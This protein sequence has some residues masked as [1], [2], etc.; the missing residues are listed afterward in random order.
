MSEK[1]TMRFSIPDPKTKEI[2][3]EN[4]LPSY[5]PGTLEQLKELSSKRKIVED[6]V[7]KTRT[8]SE[9]IAREMNRGL[10]SAC[11]QD[12]Y[13]LGQYIPLLVNLIHYIHKLGI[14]SRKARWVSA[15]KIRWSS[16][17]I[18][19]SL[20]HRKSPKFFQI[21][22]IMFE[23]GMILFLYAVKLRE[24]AME[25]ISIDMVQSATLYREAAGVFHHLSHEVLPGLQPSLPMEKPAEVI[26]SVCS[27]LSL[28][29]LAEG[30]AV[31]VKRAEEKGTSGS[32]LAKLHYGVTQLAGEANALLLLSGECKDL[33]SRFLEYVSFLG[34]LHE[35]KSQKHLAEC[36]ASEE[37]L[38]AAIGVLHRGLAAAAGRRSTAGEDTWR[39]IFRKETEEVS[40]RIDKYG[41]ENDFILRQK[42]PLETELPVPHGNKIVNLIPYSPTGW[43]REL[44][45]N[46]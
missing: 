32:L 20:L 28:L 22:D 34:A 30:Q 16:A 36:L 6:S 29:C 26:P 12:L 2:V 1:M 13:K 24:K 19:P 8:V 3:F 38:G 45:F 10:T 39:S 18:S 46:F 42:I 33:S 11:E 15:L 4:V 37:Q 41:R 7:N 21:D 14:E 23:L 31:T 17:L 9:A 44:C 40:R 27:S 43:E 25:F 5:D 35:L